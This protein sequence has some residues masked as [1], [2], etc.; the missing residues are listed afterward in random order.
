MSNFGS[1]LFVYTYIHRYVDL[2]EHFFLFIFRIHNAVINII[3]LIL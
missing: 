3:N 2:L 1:H